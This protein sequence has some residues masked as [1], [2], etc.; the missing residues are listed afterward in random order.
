MPANPDVE[1]N[2]DRAAREQRRTLLIA[3]LLALVTALAFAGVRHNGFVH[4]DDSIYIVD[5]P[6]VRGGLS[7]EALRWA[8]TEAHAGFWH[9]LTWVSHMLDV[10]L[11]GLDAGKHH[12]VSVL[13]HAL[14]A[15]LLFVALQRMTRTAWPAAIAAAFFA[16]HPMRVESVAW[17]AERKDVLSGLFWMLALL[18]YERYTRAPSAARYAAVA[19]AFV[20]GLLAKP[21]VVTLPFALLL[22][23][24]WPLGRS[25]AGAR[26]LV[27]E[28]LPLLALAALGCWI[29][30]A[31]Q[32]AFGA[33]AS[34]QGIPLAERVSN[35]F[36][37]YLHYLGS[38]FWPTRLAFFYPH[39]L[40][41][42][43][44]HRPWSSDALLGALVV[45]A[46]LVFAARARWRAPHV[47]VGVLWF[48]GTLVPVIGL[49]Q[50]GPQA[51]ADRFT[52]LPSIGIA[53]AV[54]W[55]GWR[56]AALG[57]GPRLALGG[58]AALALAACFVVTRRDVAYWRDA[59]TL[60]ERAL[61]VTEMNY[62]AHSLIGLELSQRGE[63][64]EALR[65]L[66]ESRRIHPGYKRS[67]AHL[68]NV[69]LKGGRLDE[70]VATLEQAAA[71]EPDAPEIRN[72]LGIARF[73]RNEL[74]QSIASFERALELEP[75]YAEAWNHLAMARIRA[76][77]L[78]GGRA[79]LERAL[80]LAPESGAAWNTSGVLALIERDDARAA[81][82]F[83][84]ALASDPE[85]W[86]AHA[87]LGE[88]YRRLGRAADA[89]ASL[90]RAVA[91]DPTHARAAE[92]LAWMLATAPDAALRNGREAL[93][94][95][96][97]LD[98]AAQQRNPV[99]LEL[100]AAAHAELG[101]FD[102]AVRLEERALAALPPA[103]QETARARLEGYRLRRP[104]REP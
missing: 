42:V 5:N 24:L 9:P 98:R 36:A 102:E 52:Y 59:V 25:D 20:L 63:L 80:A 7:W 84:R 49:F 104:W 37:S 78:P 33:L 16:L 35:A 81:Q 62:M 46:L 22:L 55:S 48:L 96:E 19:G 83:E 12:L 43:P 51:R 47:T 32:S 88:A 18:A 91:G 23:D 57:R 27:L 21:M 87:N 39:P 14:D 28:K 6:H 95:A 13:L 56:I 77:D 17:A 90:R 10:E 101:D 94:L 100:L 50:A 76:G 53:L 86:D 15:A 66:E 26:K 69:L 85:L 3:A 79:A 4:L 65:H 58:L 71:A 72:N 34:V 89:L 70:A 92:R 38:T 40:D 97:R 74:A 1:G 93:E 60:G 103:M 11:F 8:F 45:A 44:G 73:R 30:I 82:C 41:V 54:V 29:T 31:T 67:L 2:A 61:R 68:G 75:G 99:Y 64:E